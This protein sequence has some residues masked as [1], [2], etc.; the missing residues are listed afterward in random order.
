MAA[1]SEPSNPDSIL[2]A[3]LVSHPQPKIIDP[4]DKLQIP[5]GFRKI[6]FDTIEKFQGRAV[7][8]ADDTNLAS[9]ENFGGALDSAIEIDHEVAERNRELPGR[10]QMKF[11]I[12]VK[13]GGEVFEGDT[14]LRSGVILANRF[15]NKPNAG[16]NARL[17]PAEGGVFFKIYGWT[18]TFT[19][20][21]LLLSY[22]LGWWGLIV[23]KNYY[24]AIHGRY[25]CWP[26][27]LCDSATVTPPF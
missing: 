17:S 21:F 20:L 3:Y 16:D 5:A 10:E 11:R 26:S 14:L 27:W 23:W 2:F 25:P 15:A 18:A 4:R 7:E 22:F 19:Q 12:G 9:F 1:L 6:F 24:L 8:A 13:H